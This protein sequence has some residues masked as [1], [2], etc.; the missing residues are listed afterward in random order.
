MKSALDSSGMAPSVVTSWCVCIHYLLS[1]MCYKSR[2]VSVLVY[3]G[4]ALVVMEA[5]LLHS[6][7]GFDSIGQTYGSTI[8]I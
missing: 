3:W 8:D 7:S 1:T 2:G 6:A 5:W 4:T